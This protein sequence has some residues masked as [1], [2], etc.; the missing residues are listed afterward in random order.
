MIQTNLLKYTNPDLSDF[1][2]LTLCYA[3]DV[4]C[5]HWIWWFVS[6]W[7]EN[8]FDDVVEEFDYYFHE[9]ED[10]CLHHYCEFDYGEEC[11]LEMI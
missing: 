6:S 9:I 1:G 10:N 7:V 4:E 5:G 11:V 2:E 8:L 3:D